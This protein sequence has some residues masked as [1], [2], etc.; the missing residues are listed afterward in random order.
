MKR[1]E[2]GRAVLG[3]IAGIG[4]P[5]AFVSYP[6]TGQMAKPRERRKNT[7]M[8]VSA[9]YHVT[10]GPA[11]ISKENFDYN[12]RYGVKHINPDPVLIQSKSGPPQASARSGWGD[13]IS[14]EGPQAGAFDL[15]A[16]KR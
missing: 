1:R 13:F 12:L 8:H 4:V 9:D 11:F 6:A 10:E 2:F 14:P 7:A 5:G 15:D 3:S 16:L